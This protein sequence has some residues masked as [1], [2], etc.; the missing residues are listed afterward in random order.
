M[1]DLQLLS[2]T[3]VC[4]SS[5]ESKLSCAVFNKLMTMCNKATMNNVVSTSELTTL[6]TVTTE[7]EV[8][9]YSLLY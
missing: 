3:A 9:S 5:K 8:I 6:L 2:A 1:Y 7:Y 4:P